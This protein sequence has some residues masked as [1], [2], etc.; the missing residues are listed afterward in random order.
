M[1]DQS[2]KWNREAEA[3]E[4]SNPIQRAVHRR[5]QLLASKE[6]LKYRDREA[7]VADMADWDEMTSESRHSVILTNGSKR[8]R[9]K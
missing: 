8:P 3:S 6:R 9:K 5:K 2:E 4:G 1:R 7:F